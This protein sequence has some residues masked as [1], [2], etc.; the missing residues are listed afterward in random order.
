MVT[1]QELHEIL[2]EALKRTQAGGE[3]THEYAPSLQLTGSDGILDSLDNMLFLD[4]VDDLLSKKTGTS[5]ATAIDAALEGDRN[6]Y[7][8]MQTLAEYLLDVLH[9][10]P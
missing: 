4:N 9:E 1:L 3:V 6:P 8:S 7:K 2:A 5:V 10:R